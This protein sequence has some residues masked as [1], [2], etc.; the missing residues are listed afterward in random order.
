MTCAEIVKAHGCAS[1]HY[2]GRSF[3]AKSA[4]PI[5]GL[6]TT[7]YI[8]GNPQSKSHCQYA[9]R[10]EKGKDD[11]TETVGLTMLPTDN[12]EKPFRNALRVLLLYALGGTP[13]G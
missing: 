3:C 13:A 12:L 8:S 1:G 10:K 11:Y 5:E 9:S 4:C 7:V 2:S 6:Q